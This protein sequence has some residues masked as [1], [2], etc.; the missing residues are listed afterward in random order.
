MAYKK[1]NVEQKLRHLF[2]IS[3]HSI[4]AFIHY[5]FKFL[6]NDVTINHVRN[7]TLHNLKLN[8]DAMFLTLLKDEYF[9]EL[10]HSEI[11]SIICSLD[12]VKLCSIN[13]IP[14]M[15]NIIQ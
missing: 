14:Q 11:S 7:I 6:Q 2:E 4:D 13:D 10:L 1:L 3:N 12:S 9:V 8:D 15:P 5:L